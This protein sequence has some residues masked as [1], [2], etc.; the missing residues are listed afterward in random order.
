FSFDTYILTPPTML[1][2]VQAGGEIWSGDTP[3]DV[4]FTATHTGA[5]GLGGT[6]IWLNYSCPG[7]SGMI[8]SGDGG[9]LTSPVPWTVPAIDEVGCTVDATI[10]D[11]D[12][13][14]EV[15]ASSGLFEIDSKSPTVVSSD[16]PPLQIDV[17]ID[18]T[19][20]VTFNET[21]DT[22]SVVFTLK[23][24]VSGTEVTGALPAWT[25]VDTVLTFTPDS[26]LS[27]ATNYT[28][29]ITAAAKDISD[30]GNTLGADHVFTFTTIL[31]DEPPTVTVT[32]PTAATLWAGGA[33]ELITWTMT[34]NNGAEN[35]TVNVSYI[36]NSVSTVIATGLSGAVNY[37][38]TVACPAGASEDA[39]GVTIFVEATDASSLAAND[40]SDGFNIDCTPSGT[41]AHTGD[42]KVDKTLTF[43]ITNPSANIVTYAWD[44]GD[45]TFGSE[46]SPTHSYAEAGVYQVTCTLTDSAGNSADAAPATLTIVEEEEPVFNIMDY[47]WI[48]LIIIVVAIIAI[49]ALA[50][51]KKP[52]EEEE[53]APAEEEEEEYEEE[54][55]EEE[56]ELVEEEEVVEEEPAVE[57]EAAPAEPEP[58][59]A[60]APEAAPEAAPAAV[61]APA[62]EEAAPAE[63]APAGETKECPSCGTVVPGDASECF[64]CG[65][66][67]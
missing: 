37:S 21:M 26:S 20:V 48:I 14:F 18:T 5:G 39:S 45:G 56:E 41:V 51:R 57:E 29:T 6:Y 47:W 4:E 11:N 63:E 66:T 42:L 15:Q 31:V 22:A 8:A 7:N 46:A 10:R 50:K 60:P 64:L 33:T 43:S 17:A 3:H 12:D 53:E 16:P 32:I 62:A 30:P 65:A 61:A 44:F 9:G 55:P 67:L 34:D 27:G 38:W 19:V 13:G 25:L 28:V 1:V 2:D 23:E 59:E 49:I 24:T 35:L 40:T 58:E 52:E 54:V 36:Y